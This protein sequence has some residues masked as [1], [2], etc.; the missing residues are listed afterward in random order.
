[1]TTDQIV[2]KLRKLIRL[3][4][5]AREIGSFEEAARVAEK[6]QQW[7]MQHKI[8]ADQVNTDEV[9]EPKI[10]REKTGS[11]RTLRYGPGARVPLEDSRLMA[12]VA[13]AHFCRSLIIPESNLMYVFGEDED[14]AVCVEMFR[15][16]AR[17]MKRLARQDLKK[18]AKRLRRSTRCF[19]P[20][21]CAGF[22][23]ALR[24]RYSE[25][26]QQTEGTSTALIRTEAA[27]AK[28][29]EAFTDSTAPRRTG[30]RKR[31]N[32]NAFFAGVARGHE[33][34]LSTNVVAS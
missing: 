17:T 20:H 19:Y 16:L 7:L 4:A 31:I 22:T 21:F 12:V 32:R 28:Y 25:M 24:G 8:S 33:V 26:R 5:S 27:V 34:S 13:E 6:I 11:G 3:E 1:M 9:S 29:T 15:W 18:A 14:R 23:Y 10:G 30:K 2:D